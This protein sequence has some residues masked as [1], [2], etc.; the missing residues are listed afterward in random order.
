[1]VFLALAPRRNKRVDEH[2][3]NSFKPFDGV[4]PIREF[5][6]IEIEEVIVNNQ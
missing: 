2:S 5:K 3:W 1:M 4:Q 6:R